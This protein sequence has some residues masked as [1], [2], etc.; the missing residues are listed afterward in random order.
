[1]IYVKTPE[2]EEYEA[3]FVLEY[4]N[5]YGLVVARWIGSHFDEYLFKFYPSTTQLMDL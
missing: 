2:G 5:Y 4:P 1:M 3:T